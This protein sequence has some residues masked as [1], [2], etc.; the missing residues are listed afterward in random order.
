MTTVILFHRME[1][2]MNMLMLTPFVDTCSYLM[3]VEVNMKMKVEIVKKSSV[4]H[5]VWEMFVFQGPL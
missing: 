3:I 4:H 5:L 2:K 1:T